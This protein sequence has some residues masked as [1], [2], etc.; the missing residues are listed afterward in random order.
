VIDS[1]SG[2]P[3]SPA[4]PLYYF[5]LF[6]DDVTLGDEGVEFA[7]DDAAMVHAVAEARALAADTVLRGRLIG[8]HYIEIR[9]EGRDLVGKV[10]F[11]EA[12]EIR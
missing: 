2:T 1:E 7:D 11:D 4:V 10:R 8:S 3:Q 6:D 5:S 12:V 9:G